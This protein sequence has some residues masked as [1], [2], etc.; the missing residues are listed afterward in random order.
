VL[1]LHAAR[2]SWRGAAFEGRHVS[3]DGASREVLLLLGPPGADDETLARARAAA[4]RVIGFATPGVLPLVA[5]DAFEDRIAWCYQRFSGIGLGHVVG[6]PAGLSVRAAVQVVAAV[7][8]VLVQLEVQGV[9][10]GGPDPADLL[11]DE[12]GEV[13]I[14]GLVGPYPHPPGMRAPEGN[15]GEF[16]VVY[17]LGVLLSCLTSDASMVTPQDPAAHASMVRRVLIGAM[18]RAGAPLPERFGAWLRG[19]L[20]WERIDR[21]ALSTLPGGLTTLAMALPGDDLEAWSRAHVSALIERL[22]LSGDGARVIQDTETPGPLRDAFPDRH[23]EWD[24]LDDST[25]ETGDRRSPKR[26]LERSTPSSVQPIPVH[27]GPPPAVMEA[28]RGSLPAGFLDR[29]EVAHGVTAGM[30]RSRRDR[31]WVRWGV[32]AIVLLAIAAA[33]ASY[34]FGG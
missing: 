22:Q 10:H 7:A 28:R 32:A 20:S 17:R 24:R 21:P 6:G 16:S 15:A 25:Q 1:E 14:A 5:V 8:E 29:P 23:G 26:S 34:L 27:V 18:E 2:P 19:M 4:R 9:T 31:G 33:L 12:R 13:R 30:V 11:L 3:S